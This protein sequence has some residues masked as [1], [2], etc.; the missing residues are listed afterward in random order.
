MQGE[1]ARRRAGILAVV[2]VLTG[3]AFLLL[4]VE[5]AFAGDPLLRLQAFTTA[6]PPAV[7]G[8]RCGSPLANL[9]R[10]SD[11]LSLY[12]L[13]RDRACRQASSRR[14]A[15]AV[16]ATAVIALLGAVGLANARRQPFAA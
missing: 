9:A 15:A 6:T 11:G 14:A 1:R 8:V 13:A 4:P 12:S 7:A 10:H 3:V 2:A 16:A 5:A